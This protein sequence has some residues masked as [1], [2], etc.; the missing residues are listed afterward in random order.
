M[1]KSEQLLYEPVDTIMLRAP[2]LSL[3]HDHQ[4]ASKDDIIPILKEYIERPEIKEALAVASPNLF[5][6]LDKI[7]GDPRSKKTRNAVSSLLKFLIRMSSR[8]TPFGLFSGIAIGELGNKTVGSL[9]DTKQHQK[10]AR[11]DMEWLLGVVSKI[12]KNQTIAKKLNVVFNDA[13]Y[14]TDDRVYLHYFS[15]CGQLRSSEN[16]ER[17]DNI[18]IRKTVVVE[19]VQSVAKKPISISELINQLQLTYTSA[20]I[21]EIESFVWNLFQQEFLI[22]ELRPPIVNCAPLSY[23]IQILE[24]IPEATEIGAMLKGIEA[25]IETYNQLPIGQ[26]LDFFQT[27]T[28][29]MQ[30]IHP[31]KQ[32]LQVDLRLT[33]AEKVRINRSIGEQVANAAEWLWR[34]SKNETGVAHL[35]EYHVEFLEKYG[36]NREIP[37]LDLLSD[38]KGL[39]APPTYKYP[40]SAKSVNPP[41]MKS[42]HRL[43]MEKYI[44]CLRENAKEITLT[45][46]DLQKLMDND[47][48][49]VFA[50]NSG[51]LFV[52]VLASSAE[53]VDK[54]NYQ[55]AIGTNVGS[56]EL[57]QTFG[58]FSDMIASEENRNLMEEQKKIEET[59]TDVETEYVELSFLPQSG[60]A[61]NVSITHSTRNLHTTIATNANGQNKKLLLEDILVGA[62]LGRFYLKSKKSNKRLVFTSNNMFNYESA[63]NCFR[64]LREVSLEDGKAIQGLNLGSLREFAFIPRITSGKVI[65]S[66]AIWKI[67]DQIEELSDF[68][69]PLEEWIEQFSTWMKKMQVPERV[70]MAYGDNRLYIHLKN[71][72]HLQELR[73]ELRRRGRVQLQEIIGGYR[74]KQW[75]KSPLGRHNAEFIVPFKKRPHVPAKPTVMIKPVAEVP[76]EC[77]EKEPGTDW[78]YFKLYGPTHKQ[79]KLISTQIPTLVAELENHKLINSWFFIRYYDSEP[80][81]RL[82]FHGDPKTLLAGALPVFQ[83]WYAAQRLAG[84]VKKVVIEP[85]EREIERYGGLSLM[86]LMERYFEKDSL[87]TSNLLGLSSKQALKEPLELIASMYVVYFLTE[88]GWHHERQ[89]EWISKWSEDPAYS[90]EFR[91]YRNDVLKWLDQEENWKAL[92]EQKGFLFKLFSKNEAII[93][94]LSHNMEKT[95]M[96][97]TEER[98]VGSLIHMHCNRLLGTDR[99]REKKAMAFVRQIIESQKHWNKTKGRPLNV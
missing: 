87:L 36:V 20:S 55:L 7:H 49:D 70:F 10:R 3:S 95:P 2:I 88:Y 71:D 16:Q 84:N 83:K 47:T 72:N 89:L 75:V 30:D 58:R 76:I 92:K 17:K 66:P 21:N 8:P 99:D 61:S 25:D 41:Q 98:V 38:E 50:P 43:L 56:Q 73:S 31:S 54:G 45:E 59:C 86:P 42:T 82:R 29:K 65:L 77:R 96:T 9:S 40:P 91:P 63:P 11:P 79:Q 78:L 33:C 51:E 53:E 26:G 4:N 5:Q 19:F 67:N 37:L 85:Y 15:N 94:E 1:R 39:G 13:V 57:G 52:E 74:E 22:S 60:R 44:Q 32:P 90:K 23:V 69:M 68:S 6:S 34:L 14:Q 24:S 12:E 81:L 80:H 18:S 97:N 64:F 27:L 46:S 93:H 28:A 62:T 48:D 35:R